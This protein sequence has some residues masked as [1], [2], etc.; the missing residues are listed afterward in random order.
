MGKTSGKAMAPANGPI[1][2]GM[3][4]RIDAGHPANGAGETPAAGNVSPVDVSPGDAAEPME[5]A[6]VDPVT[7]EALPTEAVQL[8]SYFAAR[9]GELDHREAEVHARQAALEQEL[10][11][12]QMWLA[13]R[14]EE[15]AAREAKCD[16]QV[17]D[18]ERRLERVV[19]A[20][21]IRGKHDESRTDGAHAAPPPRR[22]VSRLAPVARDDQAA[23]RERT[24]LRR[25]ADLALQ[26]S[27]TQK[28]LRDAEE[29]LVEQE[30]GQQ[31]AAAAAVDQR[32]HR[33]DEAEGLL[34][35]EQQQVAAAKELLAVDRQSWVAK[36]QA[37]GEQLE[38]QRS[39]WQREREQQRSALQSQHEQQQRR[40]EALEASRQELLALHRETLEV[41]LATEELWAQISSRTAPA[42]LTQSLAMLRSRLAESYRGEI[43]QLEQ[44]QHSLATLRDALAGQLEQIKRDREQ[45][46]G[47]ARQRE[48][49]I[50]RQA[51]RLVA[52][53]QELDSQE[54]RFD[55]QATQWRE[56]QR[57]LQ[58]RVRQ[59]LAHRDVTPV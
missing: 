34:A 19:Q 39:Q 30:H 16:S 1:E 8:A 27:H 35:Q 10:R 9:Q 29:R 54:L 55:T 52:R 49:E 13:E 25:A 44:Q 11:Q 32:Q 14:E 17:R 20:D 51:S 58:A 41:R 2:G 47:W 5:L 23:V 24:A 26:L 4:T 45:F 36:M 56:E 15:L 22:D 42:T 57:T 28:R 33:L 7:A 12:A 43:G 6:P 59:L 37:E 50:E 38:Q 18:V 46:L 40:Q 48:E 53:E 21:A 31:M 3:T